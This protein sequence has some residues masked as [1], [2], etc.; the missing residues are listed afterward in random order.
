MGGRG[1]GEAWVDAGH[2]GMRYRVRREEA[3]GSDGRR[4]AG[5]ARR[6]TI[7]SVRLCVGG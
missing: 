2:W 3:R 1:K 4:A 6:D 7:G 5:A